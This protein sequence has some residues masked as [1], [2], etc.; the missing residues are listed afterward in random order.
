MMQHFGS[1]LQEI[2][3]DL[4]IISWDNYPSWLETTPAGRRFRAGM[5]HDMMRSM[6][7]ISL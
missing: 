6:K 3:A 1:R 7:K 4:D 2:Y 5:Q